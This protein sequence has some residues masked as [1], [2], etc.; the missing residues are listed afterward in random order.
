MNLGIS[1]RSALVV[2]GSRGI[3]LEVVRELR[4]EGCNVVSWSR[5]E[6]VDLMPQGAPERYSAKL[7]SA[8][9][10]VHV[11]G[12]SQGITQTLAPSSEWAKVWR[13]N[14]GIAHDINAAFIPRMQANKWG[15]IVHISSNAP[16]LNI[17]Y[18][19]Y[20]SAKSALDGYVKTVSKEFSR[21]GV[22]ISAVAP[23]IVHTP[24]RYY[25]S[26][27]SAEQE[28]F[29]NQFIPIHRFGRAEEVAKVVAFLCSEHAS[30]M[31]GSI[32]QID[33]GAR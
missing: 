12:G 13:L 20:A 11:L 29:F 9:I 15:R 17:G 3:G 31:S 32:V 7:R 5:S 22:I 16:R 18:C 23:G 26:L 8:D 21:D 25:A 14:I 30:Y 2:G 1:G 4:A 27:D 28:K 6:G 24:G 10:I 33:G 19:P